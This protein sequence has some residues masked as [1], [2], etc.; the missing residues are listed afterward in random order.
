MIQVPVQIPHKLTELVDPLRI[1]TVTGHEKFCVRIELFQ[2]FPDR[3]RAGV[4]LARLVLRLSH[5]FSLVVT[6]T[7][8]N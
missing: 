3:R 2:V 7:P 5:L 1:G 6:F 8:A 4:L